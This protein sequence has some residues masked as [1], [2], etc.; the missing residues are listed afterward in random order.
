MI[1]DPGHGT[2]HE[3]VEYFTANRSKPCPEATEWA[4]SLPDD[5]YSIEMATGPFE[6]AYFCL[7][8]FADVIGPIFRS[9]ILQRLSQDAFWAAHAW[10]TLP[11][12]PDERDLLAQGAGERY[13]KHIERGQTPLRAAT[14]MTR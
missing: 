10:A 11:L 9:I 14:L 8:E 1:F 13:R 6:Y 5:Y 4:R 3:F 12:L 7:Y 2:F